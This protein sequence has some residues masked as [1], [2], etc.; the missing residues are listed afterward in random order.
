LGQRRNLDGVSI[1]DVA[2][3]FGA[4]DAGLKPGATLQPSPGGGV[5]PPVHQTNTPP[6]FWQCSIKNHRFYKRQDNQGVGAACTWEIR[7]ELKQ[8]VQF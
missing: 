6:E 1:L 4:A 3:S 8:P 5:K 7:Y 2:P